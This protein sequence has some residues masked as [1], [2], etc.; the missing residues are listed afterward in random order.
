MFDLRQMGARSARYIPVHRP[1][2]SAT[3]KGMRDMKALLTSLIAVPLL[4][5]TLTLAIAAATGC[6]VKGWTDDGQ[7][8]RPV[9]E[10]PDMKR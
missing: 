3:R 4:I 6:V 5:S 2:V 1:M 9:F 10:C 7:G 8:G